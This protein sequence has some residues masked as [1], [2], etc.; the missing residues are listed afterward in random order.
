MKQCGQCKNSYSEDKGS[1][2][3]CGST[4]VLYPAEI[5][6]REDNS[7]AVNERMYD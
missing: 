5:K 4:K 1:C 7:P 3:K 2:P 6:V